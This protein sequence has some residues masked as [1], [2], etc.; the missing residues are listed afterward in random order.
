MSRGDDAPVALVTGSRIGIGRGIAERLL[1]AGYRVAGCSRGA[2][3][4]AHDDYVHVIADVAEERDVVNL[5]QEVHARFGRL[6]VLINNAGQASM[7]AA[8]LT[9]AASFDRIVAVNLR[10]TFLASRE[11]AKLMRRRSFGRIVNLTTVAVPLSL[12]GEAAYVASKAGVEA[13]TRVLAREL[14]PFGITVNAVGP[15]PAATALTDSVPRE[16]L[17]GLMESM[18]IKRFAEIDDIWNAMELFIRPS[19]SLLTGQIL[20]LGGPIGA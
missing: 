2:T 10:G 17:D 20:Y 5:L 15:P 9:S 4:L 8:L 1:A 18:A 16:K 11:A 7:N 6:D 14:A 12:A 3:D 13:L 19:S